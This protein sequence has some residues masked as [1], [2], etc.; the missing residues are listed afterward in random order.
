[1]WAFMVAVLG[2]YKIRGYTKWRLY[3]IRDH[4]GV[5]S[6][7]HNPTFAKPIFLS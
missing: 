5:Q 2:P 1:M 6:N 3:K 4:D 7:L